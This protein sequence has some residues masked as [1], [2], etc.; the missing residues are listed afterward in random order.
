ME[1]G[2]GP[3]DRPAPARMSPVERQGLC[4]CLDAMFEGMPDGD[5]LAAIA[6]AGL[7]R[8]E[9]WDWRGR[10]LEALARRAEA[11]GLSAVIF[12]GNTFTEP[13]LDQE[14]HP[15]ALAH[16]RHSLDASGSLGVRLLVA[17]VG[18]ALP[19]RGQAGQ[20]AA[21]VAGLRAA[22]DLAASAGVT[23]AVEPLNSKIDH[24]GY[25]LDTLG[26]AHR[27]LEEVNHQAVGLLLDLYHMWVMHDDLPERLSAVAPMVVHVH[28]AD[29]PG[30]GEPGSG[31]IPW[32]AVMER[33][34]NGGYHGPIGLE[35]WPTGDVTAALRRSAEVLAA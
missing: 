6:D 22:G 9:F 32:S 18:Y 21:A 28:A 2:A 7:S 20:W 33:L 29:V 15:A 25:F 26:E 14:R 19:Q 10:D 8:F 30:R 4:V 11:L 17:H 1:L 34:R 24:P 23:L 3:L 12:S 27:L 31:T 5:A 16:F 13:L 35:C